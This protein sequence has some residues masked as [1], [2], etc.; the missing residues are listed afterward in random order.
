M[1]DSA[2]E[3]ASPVSP[4]VDVAVDND[5]LKKALCYGIADLF[6]QR[7]DGG[8]MIGVLGAA[9]FVVAAAIQRAQLNGDLQAALSKLDEVLT[10]SVTLEPSAAEI[11]LA[12]LLETFAQRASLELD[13]G[14]SQLAA[15]TALRAIEAL[16]TGDKRAIAA[17]E[18]T[19]DGVE[20]LATIAGRVR[21]V[22]QLVLDIV[23][24]G[25]NCEDVGAAVCAEPRVDKALTICFGCHS[26]GA[27]AATVR[28]AL[29]SYIND[30]RRTAPRLLAA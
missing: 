14:E 3:V 22:E 29:A 24:S 26:G 25:T 17:L 27:N 4:V 12:A 20:G 7:D 8:V 11:E 5:V 19:L 9:R 18:R 21:C 15:M 16:H 2:V 28:A 1:I 6:W 30:V 10:E 23:D 13:G